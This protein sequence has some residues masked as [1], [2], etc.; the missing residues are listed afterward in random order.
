MPLPATV[1]TN[2]P[3]MYR[4]S[5]ASQLSSVARAHVLLRAKLAVGRKALD[6]SL[7]NKGKAMV[8]EE[9]DF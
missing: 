9:Q 8:W 5:G 4:C 2:M 6:P 7:E 3:V 1:S